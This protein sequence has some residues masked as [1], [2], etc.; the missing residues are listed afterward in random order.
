MKGN[1]VVCYDDRHVK[2][3]DNEVVSDEYPHDASHEGQDIL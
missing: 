2:S 1:Q 3:H